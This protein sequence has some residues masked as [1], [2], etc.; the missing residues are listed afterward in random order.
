MKEHKRIR[1]VLLAAL[2]LLLAGVG[3]QMYCSRTLAIAGRGTWC[4]RHC[5]TCRSRRRWDAG[6][7][8]VMRIGMRSM[9]YGFVYAKNW[10]RVAGVEP[11]ASE[12]RAPSYSALRARCARPQSPPLAHPPGNCPR[13][14]ALPGNA[15]P[16][17]LCRTDAR[18][19]LIGSRLFCGTE[20]YISYHLK[21]KAGAQERGLAPSGI[22]QIA[23]KD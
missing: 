3:V 21:V 2:A 12:W 13:S 7:W 16:C 11:R 1:P 14:Q 15:R 22:S 5:T 8:A 23:G 9:N 19:S 10:C 4:W 18:Q 6:D 17:R 20:T